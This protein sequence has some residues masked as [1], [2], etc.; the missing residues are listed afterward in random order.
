MI[1]DSSTGVYWNWQLAGV[2]SEQKALQAGYLETPDAGKAYIGQAFGDKV[3]AG[4]APGRVNKSGYFELYSPTLVAQGLPGLPSYVA[5]PEHT[6]I[7]QGQL[8]LSTFK[9]N[10]QTASTTANSSC[11]RY[12]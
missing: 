6:S 7:Q 9:V 10:V 4:F 3:Y 8:I 2:E 5:I 11:K 12:S 1:L